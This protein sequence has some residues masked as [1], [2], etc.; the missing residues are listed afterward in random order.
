MAISACHF[1]VIAPKGETD[2]SA[3]ELTE[4]LAG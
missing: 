4:G 2:R 3:A 1:S